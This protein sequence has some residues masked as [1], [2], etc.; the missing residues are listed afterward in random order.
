MQAAPSY[1]PPQQSYP[2]HA[3]PN[4][5]RPLPPRNI[6]AKLGGKE[7]IMT[8]S[9]D[10]KQAAHEKPLGKKPAAHAKAAHKAA[11]SRAKPVVASRA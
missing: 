6:G 10:K 8:G 4:P 2:S 1:A 5:N 9:I 11:E 3:V 7:E